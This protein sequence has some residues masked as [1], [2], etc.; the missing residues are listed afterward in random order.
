MLC[1]LLVQRLQ[2]VACRL[3][4][5]DAGEAIAQQSPLDVVTR[6]GVSAGEIDGC[7][8]VVYG[9]IQAESAAGHGHPLRFHLRLVAHSFGCGN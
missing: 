4:L 5:V 1:C 2:T 8:R 6:R 7:E 9:P 3:I